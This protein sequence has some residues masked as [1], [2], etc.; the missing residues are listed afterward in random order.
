MKVAVIDRA[1]MAETWGNGPHRMIVRT[2]E[3]G[4]V[5]P[6]CGGPR[7]VPYGHNGHEDGEWYHVDRWDNP[8]GHRDRYE[9][10]L[11]EAADAG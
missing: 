4:D 6:Q 11:K 2:V 9:D 8:C 7:G 3:I 5:C 10:V 1:A